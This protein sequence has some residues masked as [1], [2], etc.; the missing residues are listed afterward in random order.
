MSI[1]HLFQEYTR[2]PY[3]ELQWYYDMKLTIIGVCKD[4][5]C[6]LSV[7]PQEMAQCVSGL[8]SSSIARTVPNPW[9]NPYLSYYPNQFGYVILWGNFSVWVSDWDFGPAWTYANR[10]L[11]K[12]A[13]QSC[14][15]ASVGGTME[16]MD[17][18]LGFQRGSQHFV[19]T[20]PDTNTSSS[21]WQQTYKA[22][23]NLCEN[24]RI[25]T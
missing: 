5:G 22:I 8:I 12:E 23:S 16:T 20:V 17:M 21:D 6:Q 3:M 18:N 11:D 19:E 7:P 9:V 15:N 13:L 14:L 2:D 4:S 24:V 10:H 25:A 1:N